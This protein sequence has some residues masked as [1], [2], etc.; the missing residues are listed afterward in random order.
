MA[1]ASRYTVALHALTWI[2]QMAVDKDDYVPSNQVAV[3]VGT[4]SVFIRRILG[5]LKKSG[6]GQCK[7]WGDRDW[8]EISK[9]PSRHFAIGGI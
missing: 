4:S 3:S 2:A 1:I 8:L 6:P 5:K 7:T 9:K